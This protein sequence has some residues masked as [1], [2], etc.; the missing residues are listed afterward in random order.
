M[1]PTSIIDAHT[2]FYDPTRPEGVPWPHPT[3]ALL[4]RQVLPRHFR[5]LAEPLGVGGTVVVEASSWLADNDWILGL[6]ESERCI[7]GFI[8][9]AEPG[10]TFEREL[11]RLAARPLFR[12]I[13]LSGAHLAAESFAG[14]MRALEALARR[15]LTVDLLVREG[16][17]DGATE[18]ASRIPELNVVIDHLGGLR[19]DGAS[20][21]PEWRDRMALLAACPGVSCK[22]SGYVEAAASR[23]G[24]SRPEFY[25][26][27][28]ET[29]LGLFGRD[30]LLFG[31]NWPVCELGGSYDTVVSVARHFAGRQGPGFEELFFRANA[32][33]A[34]GLAHTGRGGK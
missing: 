7:V 14:T 18:V 2:H 27:V 23:P 21:P 31:S 16:E 25:L 6:A 19:I 8:G 28:L 5:E 26:P 24:P 32:A 13:R 12:G 10:G 11:D 33:R 20:P 17:L 3:E 29:A 22:V 15:G 9:H 34:Y 4:Y 1:A 30:R